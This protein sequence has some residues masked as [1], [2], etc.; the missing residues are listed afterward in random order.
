M[1]LWNAKK[2]NTLKLG[3]KG[4]LLAGLKITSLEKVVSRDSGNDFGRFSVSFFEGRIS[5]IR[6]VYIR[7]KRYNGGDTNKN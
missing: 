7:P 4:L 6:A 3:Q 1:E 5:Y 2:S